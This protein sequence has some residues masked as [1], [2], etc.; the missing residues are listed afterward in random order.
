MR[1]WW[2]EVKFEAWPARA[3]ALQPPLPFDVPSPTQEPLQPTTTMPARQ[4]SKRQAKRPLM[5]R[6]PRGIPQS[7]PKTGRKGKQVTDVEKGMIIALW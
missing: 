6:P 2:K 4:N 5:P 7:E 3:L 1:K